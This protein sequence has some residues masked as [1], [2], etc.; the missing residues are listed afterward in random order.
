MWWRRHRFFIPAMEKHVLNLFQRQVGCPVCICDV[1]LKRMLCRE[2][3]SVQISCLWNISESTVA[4]EALHR[5][6]KRVEVEGEGSSVIQ[7]RGEAWWEELHRLSQLIK[8]RGSAVHTVP[9]PEGEMLGGWWRAEESWWRGL[10]VQACLM[11]LCLCAM[12]GGKK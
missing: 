6:K 4:P 11:C 2:D 3:K 1:G 7:G 10:R 8:G 12:G 5:P 9:C